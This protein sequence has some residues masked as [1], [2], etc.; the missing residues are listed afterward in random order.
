MTQPRRPQ[1]STPA[2]GLRDEGLQRAL[3]AILV[4]GNYQGLPKLAEGIARQ[5]G[6]VTTHQVRRVFGEVQ[7]IQLLLE[8]PDQEAARRRLLM[9]PPRIAYQA[10]RERRLEPLK[11]TVDQAV[12]IVSEAI[13]E[14]FGHF[15]DLMEAVVSYHTAQAR[16]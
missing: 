11:R 2:S 6:G 12:P 14:R 4:Q 3:Q 7:R 13:S 10:A 1:P 15:Y 9:L 16:R 5:L 8:K